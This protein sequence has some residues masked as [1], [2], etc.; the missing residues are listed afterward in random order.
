MHLAASRETAGTV[1]GPT[2]VVEDAG[3]ASALQ[4]Q[5]A[6][7]APAMQATGPTP[8]APASVT[9]PPIASPEPPT[10]PHTGDAAH[11]QPA[12]GDAG[13]TDAARAVSAPAPAPAGVVDTPRTDPA[14]LR[15][16]APA[17]APE[18]VASTDAIAH[19]PASLAASTPHATDAAEDATRASTAAAATAV[20]TR[21]GQPAALRGAPTALRGDG[22]AD[23]AIAADGIRP[24]RIDASRD[25]DSDGDAGRQG[26]RDAHAAGERRAASADAY[27]A[28][29]VPDALDASVEQARATDATAAPPSAPPSP[30]PRVPA[31]PSFAR[32]AVARAPVDRR[33]ALLRGGAIGALAL[34]LLVQLLL[35]DRAVLAADARWRPLVAAACGALRCTLPPWRE[36]HAFQVLERDV[37]AHPTR[38]GVLRVSARMRNDARWAQPWPLLRLTLSDVHGRAVASR[39]FRPREYLGGAPT[40]SALA[41]GHS[42]ALVMEIVEPGPQAVAFTFDF[43]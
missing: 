22:G 39:A 14:P 16:S 37:R 42:A 17:D 29:N 2:A 15:T 13:N 6:A 10:D 41:S 31:S 34:L 38:A 25:A 7:D 40:Q 20:G 43:E 3:T 5:T 27:D 19:D 26:D 33:R 30:L 36:P 24:A 32:R 9:F 12:A 18:A 11:A 4:S 35:A 1:I 28:P 23:D 8:P 21:A